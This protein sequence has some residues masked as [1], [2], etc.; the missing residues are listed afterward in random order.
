M[1]KKKITITSLTILACGISLTACSENKSMVKP[2]TI[3]YTQA[4]KGT[5]KKKINKDLAKK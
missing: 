2:K 3:S 1:N 5:N 4:Y